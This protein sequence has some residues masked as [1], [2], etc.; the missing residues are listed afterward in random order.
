MFN[1]FFKIFLY[2]AAKWFLALI[3]SLIWL[4]LGVA[5]EDNLQSLVLDTHMLLFYF[6]FIPGSLLLLPIV[7]RAFKDSNQSRLNQIQLQNL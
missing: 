3:L 5:L 6:L 4:K 1:L 2:P 7:F